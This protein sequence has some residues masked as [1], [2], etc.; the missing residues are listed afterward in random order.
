MA[1]NA[2]DHL[3]RQAVLEITRLREEMLSAQKKEK[4]RLAAQHAAR[5]TLRSGAFLSAVEQ[6][7]EQRLLTFGG[8][9]VNASIEIAMLS[10]APAGADLDA[11][12]NQMFEQHFVS[13]A[14]SFAVALSES[15]KQQGVP[16]DGVWDQI[17]STIFRARRDR[18]IALGRLILQAGMEVK[19]AQRDSA[20]SEHVIGDVDDIALSAN[21]LQ[22]VLGIARTLDLDLRCRAINLAQILVAELNPRGAE[23]FLESMPLGGPRNRRDPRFLR[24]QPGQCN[25]RRCR[26]PLFRERL[27]PR[28]ERQVGFPVLLREAWHDVAEVR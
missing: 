6:D 24:Q 4:D 27:Q 16:G 13:A 15:R 26:V 10:G 14:T 12:V 7:V 1:W 17:N 20:L 21:H 11:W 5:G 3:E 2:S 8:A 19:P 23:V 25:L 18:D 22:Q 28:H 9:V